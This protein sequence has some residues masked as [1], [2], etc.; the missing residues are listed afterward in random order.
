MKFE[1][2]AKHR[3]AWPVAMLCGALGVSR[4]GY[5]AW[6]ERSPSDRSVKQKTLSKLVRQS[7]HRQR[8][9]VRRSARLAR[10][11]GQWHELRAAPGREADAAPGPACKA[12]AT[13]IAQGRR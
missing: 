7:C 4:S 11:V 6:L 5:Y 8:S 9:D 2:V 13:W 1:F 12:S 10:R 3:G